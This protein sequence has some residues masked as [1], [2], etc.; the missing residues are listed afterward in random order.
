MGLWTEERA[1]GQPSEIG[2]KVVVQVYEEELSKT[3]RVELIDLFEDIGLELVGESDVDP[4]GCD[5]G[6]AEKYH[7]F[8]FG[9]PEEEEEEES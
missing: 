7:E 2:M 4:V 8:V 6:A 9:I 1:Q 3:T 5:V